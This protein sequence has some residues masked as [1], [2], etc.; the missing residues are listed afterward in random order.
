MG[1]KV[2][3]LLVGIVSQTYTWLMLIEAIGI[4]LEWIL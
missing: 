4:E 2:S 3:G 1:L